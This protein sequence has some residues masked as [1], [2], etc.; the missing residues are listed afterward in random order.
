VA[1]N[2][3]VIEPDGYGYLQVYPCD[4]AS[5]SNISNINYVPMD[6]RPNSVVTPVDDQG[7]ICLRSYRDTDVAVDFTGYFAADGGLDFV[8]LDPIRL[9][10]SRSAYRQLNESTNGR[11]L[12][13]NQVVRLKIAGERGVPASAK[14]V[15]INLTATDVANASY[16][17]V[18][19]CGVRPNTS[20][21]NIVAAQF[22]TANGAM[23]KLSTDG[24][25]CVYSK[26][27]VHVIIDINGVW[28]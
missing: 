13:A 6:Y 5:S 7:R 19:P 21:V 10:D 4:A 2:V 14:A 28:E 8:P 22:V 15:S 17:T 16:L 1:L 20:N 3:T 24:D 25:L 11:R 18:Y 26:H 12:A 23:V 9:F 27:D